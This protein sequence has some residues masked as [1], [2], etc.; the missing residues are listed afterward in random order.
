MDFKDAVKSLADKLALYKN[1]IDNEESTKTALILPFIKLLGYDIHNPAFFRC[2]YPC[3]FAGYTS[4]RADYA[5]VDAVGNPF[6]LIEA[7]PLGTNLDKYYGQIQAYYLA[8]RPAFIMLT[9]GNEYRLYSDI[10]KKGFFDAKPCVLLRLEDDNDPTAFYKILR[11][12]NTPAQARKIAAAYK[13]IDDGGV[14]PPL[15][16]ITAEALFAE[17]KKALAGIAGDNDITLRQAK[18]YYACTPANKKQSFCRFQFLKS[19]TDLIFK[20]YME[21]EERHQIN[22]PADIA[23]YKNDIIK[24]YNQVK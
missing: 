13:I 18:M 5:I 22:S 17:V 14:T 15:P 1:Y 19:R 7:K 20:M 12:G 2:E 9:D 10:D 24:Y 4:A 3:P 23:Q 21:D 16:N 11:H 8:A 6:L